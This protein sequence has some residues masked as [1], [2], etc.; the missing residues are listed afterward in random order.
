MIRDRHNS[1]DL[2]HCRPASHAVL[3]RHELLTPA[4][5]SNHCNDFLR[6]N[7]ATPS[8][9]R[10]AMLAC[11]LLGWHKTL[12][13][14]PPAA[15]PPVMSS[16]WWSITDG[17]YLAS[18]PCCAFSLVAATWR[19]GVWVAV[20]PSASGGFY[21]ASRAALASILPVRTPLPAS[22]LYSSLR[23]KFNPERKPSC[24]LVGRRWLLRLSALADSDGSMGASSL[25]CLARLAPRLFCLCVALASGLYSCG[26]CLLLPPPG[27]LGLGSPWHHRSWWICLRWLGRSGLY[28]DQF[29][30]PSLPPSCTHPGSDG[31]VGR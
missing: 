27:A 9:A 26:V 29:A 11:V 1:Y 10:V 23:E 20:A 18:H 2:F 4:V 14:A 31:T 22:L 24:E 3:S 7:M 6:L 30:R 13:Q 25:P 12:A 8:P 16:E 19:T 5:S 21:V 17:T 28:P 15:P